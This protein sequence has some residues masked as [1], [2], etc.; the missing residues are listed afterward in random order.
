M[1]GDESLE[2]ELLLGGPLAREMADWAS[3]WA[4]LMHVESLLESRN[5]TPNT[6]VNAFI[7][8]GMWEAALVSYGRTVNSGRRR[9][10][11]ELVECF[12]CEQLKIHEIILTWRNQHVAH[13]VDPD[14]ETTVVAALADEARSR[15]YGLRVH[16]SPTFGP[17]F[18]DPDLEKSFQAHV[19]RLRNQIWEEYL[20]PLKL[21]LL[22]E[23]GDAVLAVAPLVDLP[24]EE[25]GVRFSLDI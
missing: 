19:Y 9:G 15:I 11:Q 20:V 22:S 2:I 18:D 4:D 14:R 23:C 21:R 12:D 25:R 13:R 1:A 10:M 7:R 16:V 8:R 5:N 24:V 17:D 3:I 6:P